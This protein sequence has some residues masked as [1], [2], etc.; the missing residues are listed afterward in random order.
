VVYFKPEASP[1]V[2]IFSDDDTDSAESDS[3]YDSEHDSDVEMHME[4]DVD[5]PD[6]VDLDGDV[7]KKRDGEDEEDDEEEDEKGED[8]MDQD[9]EE[10]NG[11]EPWTIGQG[12]MVNTSAEDADTMVDDKPPVVPKQGHWMREHT[13]HP[14]PLAS[15]PPPDTREPHPRPRPRSP[16]AHTLSGVEILGFITLQKPRPVAP[17][18]R[19]A[20]AARITSDVDVEQ[21]LLSK[22]AG[23]DSLP[24]VP[25]QSVPLP[26][27]PL[28]DGHLPNVPLP[29]TPGWLG[30]PG[31]NQ[32]SCCGG[33]ACSG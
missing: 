2:S 9:E 32:S 8:E 14:Q 30:M 25:F 13:P 16:K 23:G 31:V 26:D 3:E 33:A 1:A 7:D 24:D 18:Q 12:E 4:D 10:D 11:K 15:A 21:Q 29:Q 20:D 6:G 19:E 5:A 17:T 27:V 22:S 28:P